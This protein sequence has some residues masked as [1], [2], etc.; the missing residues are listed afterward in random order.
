MGVLRFAYWRVRA[1]AHHTARIVL[2]TPAAPITTMTRLTCCFSRDF[3]IISS[4]GGQLGAKNFLKYFNELS[5]K[6][7]I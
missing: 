2:T 6:L 3:T 7:R 4:L 5:K 1:A